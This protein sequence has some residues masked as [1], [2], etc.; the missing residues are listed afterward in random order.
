MAHPYNKFRQSSV[1]RSRVGELT[2]GYDGGGVSKPGLSANPAKQRK[3]GGSVKSDND[4]DDM[5]MAKRRADR[6]QRRAD[7]GRADGD[8][9]YVKSAP[10]TATDKAFYDKR[11]DTTNDQIYAT[12]KPDPDGSVAM[13]R[14]MLKRASGGRTKKPGVVVN[15]IAGGQQQ[16]P[17]PPMMPPPG[18][19]PMPPGPPPGAMPPPGGPPMGMKPPGLGGAGPMP[20]PGMPMR[21]KGGKVKRRDDGG[22]VTAPQIG[23][24]GVAITSY[25]NRQY[26][27]RGIGST[28]TNM[29][30][31]QAR[32]SAAQ[33]ADYDKRMTSPDAVD[34]TRAKGGGVKSVGM[35]VGTK[36]QHDKAHN[37]TDDMKRPGMKMHPKVVTFKT[38]GGVVSFKTGGKV[39]E[40]GGATWNE[41]SGRAML[42]DRKSAGM[43]HQTGAYT[44]GPSRA[45][46]GKV[47]MDAGTGSG[48]GRLEQAART[49]RNYH[50]PLK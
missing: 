38:G 1:E 46:G 23:S 39:R 49:K 2:S 43:R 44:G 48:E 5:P 28:P 29:A 40:A 20:P 27:P 22:E 6:K 9:F 18:P 31:S 24:D 35:K 10:E 14:S 47:E 12:T 8:G 4:A 25:G 17:P 13:A 41:G 33:N 42:E 21:A 36:V 7:G 3:R 50:G 19:P 34:V 15:V 16:P 45:K 32:R 26:V 11:P 37:D 30:A